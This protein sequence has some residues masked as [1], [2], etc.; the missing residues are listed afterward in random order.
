MK[1]WYRSY[2]WTLIALVA[3]PL[4]GCAQ[5]SS[6]LSRFSK[7]AESQKLAA[8][9]DESKSK[10]APSK[11]SAIVSG[12][13]SAKDLDSRASATDLA[14]K[15]KTKPKVTSSDK[16][17]SDRTLSKTGDPTKPEAKHGQRTPDQSSDSLIAD[18]ADTRETDSAIAKTERSIS[19][20]DS[21]RKKTVTSSRSVKPRDAAREISQTSASSEKKMIQERSSVEHD[22]DIQKAAHKIEDKLAEISDI[23]EWASESKSAAKK[24]VCSDSASKEVLGDTSDLAK[25]VKSSVNK[26]AAVSENTWND[27]ESLLE[28]SL[29]EVS[30]TAI[31]TAKSTAQNVLDQGA[32]AD[33]YL[34]EQIAL[35]ETKDLEV[36]KRRL[37]QIGR[38][39]ADAEAAGPKLQQLL[40]HQDGFVRTHA[41]LALVRTGQTS[42]DVVRIVVDGLK[43]PD[44]GLRSFAAVSLGEMGPAADEAISTLAPCLKDRD[45]NVRLHAAEVLIRHDQWSYQSLEALLGCLKDKSEN[46]RW[47]TTYSLAELAPEDSDAVD[48]LVKAT[49]DP[50]LKVRI[51]AVYAL[52]EIGPFAR[53]SAPALH[54][55]AEETDQAELKTAVSYAIQQIES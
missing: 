44:P 13:K 48:A 36:L 15:T 17:S 12:D 55:L 27:G 46:V 5:Q 10:E 38:M 29:Q 31:A 23:P 24:D 26:I 14:K 3:I 25:D 51:G 35:L 6:W 37:H 18:E 50:S 20:A 21:A 1:T 28:T 42:A 41:A 32:K 4:T 40:T 45:G 34:Q 52:G 33:Q 22:A 53:K 8:V 11:K 54:R 16:S 2:N 39:G 47:L 19:G 30:T 7:T 43:S 49:G 9:D